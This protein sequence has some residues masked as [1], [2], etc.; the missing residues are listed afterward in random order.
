MQSDSTKTCKRCRQ[1]LPIKAF[2]TYDNGAGRRPRGTCHKCRQN[3]DRL[4]RKPVQKTYPTEKTCKGCQ[5]TFPIEEFVLCKANNGTSYRYTYC[6]SCAVK[7]HK[8]W[9]Q[10][11][12]GQ[13]C[14]RTINLRAYG[15]THNQYDAMVAHQNNV[16]A[17]C[18]R[19]ETRRSRNGG[20]RPLAVDH[21]HTTGQV[22]G[23]VCSSCNSGLGYFQD[24]PVLLQAAITYLL[25]S[26]S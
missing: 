11:P 13:K 7:I 21:N 25:Q 16:C 3:K 2:P 20:I 1:D 26:R 18:H 22:R 6:K 14:H 17:I 8:V 5:Q 10:T 9:Q 12:E 24:D 19:P 4:S 15:L 23:L